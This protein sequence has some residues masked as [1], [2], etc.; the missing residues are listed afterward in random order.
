MLLLAALT[1][2]FSLYRLRRRVP[3]WMSVPG[4]A[5][6][7]GALLG[8][9]FTSHA[10]G[11]ESWREIAVASDVIHQW[12]VALW[13]G[14]LIHLVL[15]WST[16]DETRQSGAIRRYS[17]YALV[18][19]GL[20]V[21]TGVANAAF[22]FPA[23]DTLWN[24]DYGYV[25]IAKVLV[26]LVPLA[27]AVYHRRVIDVAKSIP[28]LFRTTLRA[29]AVLAVIVLLGGATL[30]LSAPPVEEESGPDHVALFQFEKNE[31]GETVG[32]VHLRISPVRQGDNEIEVWLTDTQGNVVS[33]SAVPGV[34][35]NFTSLDHGT[36][37]NVVNLT[38]I[39]SAARRYAVD[40]LDLS[41]DG[42]WQ[43]DATITSATSEL[44]HASFYLLLPDP[45]VHGSSAAPS[46]DDNP[47]ARAIF[48]RAVAAMQSRQKFKWGESINTGDDTMVLVNYGQIAEARDQPASVEQVLAYSGSFT[49]R[50][51][52][53]LPPPPTTNTY[54]SVT[55][56][57][58]SW[59]VQNDGAWLEQPA[60]RYGTIATWGSIYE[61]AEYLRFGGTAE[62]NGRQMQLISFHTP[63]QTG[64][65]EAWFCWWV[66]VETGDVNR[67]AMVAASHYMVWTYSEFDGAFL[68]GPPPADSEGTPV[69]T[70][71]A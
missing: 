22:V 59:L 56:G 34:A 11:R 28:T 65:S 18:L 17:R 5:F 47:D 29:E 37:S 32:L 16:D 55:I 7:L 4:G 53:S 25:L 39:D 8:L 9:S 10:A 20:G 33:D 27:L 64:Q 1:G 71:A 35:L 14:G 19:F 6:S 43:I 23:L 3:M 50:S 69:A 40:G 12:S 68:I 52:G 49:A 2:I 66:D 15:A 13:V 30:A 51:D 24:S 67:I 57:D 38:P 70:P 48:D 54:H 46:P 61:L 21:L 26:L 62:I 42:W 41:L 44:T 36:L 63:N 45:N 60:G 58:Q 31:L